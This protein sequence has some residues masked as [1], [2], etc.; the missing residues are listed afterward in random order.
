MS[1][2]RLSVSLLAN[3]LCLQTTD[4]RPYNF[5]VKK[6]NPDT[7]AWKAGVQSGDMIVQVRL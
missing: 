7:L 4:G 5:F 1:L 3:V 2:F 6:V